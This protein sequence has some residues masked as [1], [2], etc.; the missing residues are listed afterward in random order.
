M[1]LKSTRCKLQE[2]NDAITAVMDGQSFTI[3]GVTFTRARLSELQMREEYLQNQLA[4]ENG[5]RPFM[6]TVGF[7]GMAY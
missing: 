1:A 4:K 3:D 2:V 7:G 6:K 5:K